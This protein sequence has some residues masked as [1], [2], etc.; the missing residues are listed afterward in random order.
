MLLEGFEQKQ[1]TKKGEVERP[2][3]LSNLRDNSSLDQGVSP[4]KCRMFRFDTQ[5]FEDRA[6]GRLW[7]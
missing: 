3:Q 1:R 4:R 6:T 2:W 5:Y 7:S